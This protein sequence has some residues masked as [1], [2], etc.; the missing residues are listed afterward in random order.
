[1][2]TLRI[3]SLSLLVGC[4]LNAMEE[5]KFA[6]TPK[7]V[8]SLFKQAS[9]RVCA[10]TH[11]L[12]EQIFKGCSENTA[13]NTIIVT[14]NELKNLLP[15]EVFARSGLSCALFSGNTRAT[16]LIE[17]VAD[18][19]ITQLQTESRNEFLNH[20]LFLS[21]MKAIPESAHQFAFEACMNE[22][23]DGFLDDFLAEIG[24]AAMSDR[25]A[26]A[27]SDPEGAVQH[28][29][30][31]LVPNPL[32]QSIVI[33]YFTQQYQWDYSQPAQEITQALTDETNIN[34]IAW[35]N[36]RKQLAMGYDDGRI[37]LFDVDNRKITSFEQLHEDCVTSI[38]YNQTAQQLITACEDRTL[39]V[40]D[41][42]TNQCV[43]TVT[44]ARPIEAATFVHGTRYIALGLHDKIVL[45]DLQNN[46][47]FHFLSQS[48]DGH[49][50]AII[51]ALCCSPTDNRLISFDQNHTVKVWDLATK[52]CTVT[53]NPVNKMGAALGI[54]YH[55][56]EQVLKTLTSDTVNICDL[57]HPERVVESSD[58]EPYQVLVQA[59]QQ[60][61]TIAQTPTMAYDHDRHILFSLDF[62]GVDAS[63][64]ATFAQLCIIMAQDQAE[65]NLEDQQE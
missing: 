53:S 48:T 60:P 65:K 44:F 62:G 11:A 47:L 52:E 29:M 55:P 18:D 57:E 43:K 21:L 40:W 23:D 8:S 51:C 10:S 31:R 42:T 58:N 25:D 63:L 14:L 22:M 6:P 20:P 50:Q 30:I 12:L 24:T 46:Q 36:D 38:L 1:M 56:I 17:Q 39:R 2:N 32:I 41:L 9:V 49:A 33:N 15:D 34:V 19:I 13:S 28:A 54:V 35:L 37:A 59:L 3:L 5:P 16:Q 64:P 7:S 27:Q 45:Y 4:A 61:G 26:S